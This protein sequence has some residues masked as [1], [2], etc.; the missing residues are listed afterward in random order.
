MLEAIDLPELITETEQ[1]YQ[2]LILKL[3]TDPK[4]L[5]E[6]KRKLTFN[7]S[8]KPLFNTELFTKHLENGYQQAYDRYFDD[9]KPK[10]I[11]VLVNL[12]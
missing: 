6:I 3:A 5:I 8:S 4:Q 2:A 1:E 7:L 11:N 12:S 10:K 9:K